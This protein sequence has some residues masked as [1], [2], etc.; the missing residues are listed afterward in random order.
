MPRKMAG[1]ATMTIDPSI[2]AM[3][4]LSVVLDSAIHRYLSGR[5]S[6]CGAPAV[7]SGIPFTWSEPTLFRTLAKS[8]ANHLPDGN[9]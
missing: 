2:V 1:I 3:V 4:M 7:V 8:T 9:Y 5:A 6:A